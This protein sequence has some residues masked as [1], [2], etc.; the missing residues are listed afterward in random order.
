M[1]D[2]PLLAEDMLSWSIEKKHRRGRNSTWWGT[3]AAWKEHFELF[4]NFDRKKTF[5]IV[6]TVRDLFL[7]VICQNEET[8]QAETGA[9]KTS[10]TATGPFFK[11]SCIP[12]TLKYSR[13]IT[14]TL[15]KHR[16]WGP[17]YAGSQ[18]LPPKVSTLLPAQP[19]DDPS[20]E[21]V[22]PSLK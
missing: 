7:V 10:S 5:K 22:W 2:F 20:S 1:L 4:G 21:R 17:T 9:N 15:L 11:G 6:F 13:H 12:S 16:T 19:C 18:W 14:L 3:D 8:R